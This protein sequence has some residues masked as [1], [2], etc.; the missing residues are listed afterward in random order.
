MEGNA[1]NVFWAITII[2]YVIGVI[3]GLKIIYNP[4]NYVTS[5]QCIEASGPTRANPYYGDGPECE[6]YGYVK[7][8]ENLLVPLIIHGGAGAFVAG[9]I[10]LPIS[11][12]VEKIESKK[13]VPTENQN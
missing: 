12:I 1:K 10:A 11:M 9:W 4:D 6:R 7:G 3:I 2:G 5:R 8:R 13:K